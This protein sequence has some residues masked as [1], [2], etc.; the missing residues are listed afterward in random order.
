MYKIMLAFRYLYRRRITSLAIVSIALCVFI[1]VVVMTVMTGLV[2]NFKDKNHN[3]VG[4]CVV[5][6]ES[7]VGFAYYEDFLEE[8][9]GQD[10]VAAVSAVVN[11]YGLLTKPRAD[12]NLA[13]QI[14]G[15]DAAQHSKATGFAET[16]YYH[17]DDPSLAFVPGYDDGLIGCVVGI[18]HNVLG[19]ARDHSG[20]Y[21][22]SREPVFS[23]YI[24]SCIPL[25][26]KGGLA[27]AGTDVVNTKSFYFSD[28]SHSGLVKMDSNV[29]YLPIEEAQVL[30]GMGGRTKRISA[31]H[32][33]FAEGVRLGDGTEKVAGLWQKHIHANKDAKYAN[34]F[35]NV[36]VQSW[37]DHRRTSIAAMQKEQ[38]MLTFLFAMLGVIT[39]FIILVVFYMIVSSKSKDIGILKS[40]GVSQFN[41]VSVFLLFS[42]LIGLIGAGIGAGLGAGVLY[43]ANDIEDWLFV[44]F[45]WQVWDRSVYAIGKIPNDID[46]TVMTIIIASAVAASMLGAFLPSMQA[47]RK[48]V[49]RILQV[50]QL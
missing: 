49:A 4:D 47:S 43:K 9:R 11:G 50:N 32:I 27:K 34:L 18:D 44:K 12:W 46:W 38:T 7:L 36:T 5:S 20:E 24:I 29:V 35:D 8:L 1:V 13:A 41:L 28:D 45:G 31:I 39:V 37:I 21:Y 16:L 26:A 42:L 48:E 33:K 22:H 40:V 3:F 15:I 10:H 6:T 23:E 17:K 2:N 19:K 30:C 14:K 25:T